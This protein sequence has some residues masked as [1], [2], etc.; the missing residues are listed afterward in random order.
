MKAGMPFKDKDKVVWPAAPAQPKLFYP[1]VEAVDDPVQWSAFEF[2]EDDASEALVRL[3]RAA[4]PVLPD[5]APVPA[6]VPIPVPVDVPD[7][8]AAPAE[9]L[10][11][12]SESDAVDEKFSDDDVPPDDALTRHSS[13]TVLP[14][15]V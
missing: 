3:K 12:E 15:L 10:S 6:E 4:P 2:D 8:V 7:P 5:V 1:T 9:D 14:R 13:R 11:S